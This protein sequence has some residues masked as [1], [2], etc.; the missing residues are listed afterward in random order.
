MAQLMK[1]VIATAFKTAVKPFGLTIKRRIAGRP[2]RFSPSTDI[3]FMLLAKG[4]FE[5]DEIGI[6]SKLLAD[7]S[8]VIDIGANIGLHA[9]HFASRC[10]NGLIVAIEPS[11]GTFKIL[12]ENIDGIHNVVALNLAVASDN[13]LSTFYLAADNAYSSLKDTKRKSIVGTQTVMCYTVDHLLSDIL[14]D[15]RIDLIKIDV[16][17]LEGEVLSGMRSIMQAHAPVVFCEIHRGTNSNADPL[18]TIRYCESLGYRTYSL[19]NGKLEQFVNHDDRYDNY[20]F[21]PTTK[22][23]DTLAKL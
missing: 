13:R 1:S 5:S 6:C 20:L 17:G 2:F 14:R 15:K 3:G 9:V 12:S 10:R 19:R 4:A 7:D 16:E 21:I 22:L 8:T 18:Q 23:A 11:V